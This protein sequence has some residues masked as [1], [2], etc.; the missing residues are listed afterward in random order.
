MLTWISHLTKGTKIKYFTAYGIESE[1]E[2]MRTYENGDVVVKDAKGNVFT[3]RA[4]QL[5]N[6]NARK[7]YA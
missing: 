4:N 1:V 6:P 2:V 3:A 5:Q 7:A